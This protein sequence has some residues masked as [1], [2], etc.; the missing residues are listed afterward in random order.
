MGSS[1]QRG[2]SVV[3]L[4]L[5]GL[6]AAGCGRRTILAAEAD[7]I[8]PD[9]GPIVYA[10]GRGKMPCDPDDFGG[11]S[12]ES[13]GFSGGE[14][15]CNTNT[16]NLDLGDCVGGFSVV[17]AGTDA[18]TPMSGRNGAPGGGSG[19]QSSGLFGGAAGAGTGAAAGS[20]AALFGGL[21]GGSGSGGLFGGG[22]AMPDAGGTRRDAGPD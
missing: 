5:A 3:L 6:C 14:L 13:L 9:A 1:F 12:C 21:F 11:K 19:G 8:E 7:E 20:G 22:N 4:L 15:G 18:G 2:R 17:D 16:C 10:C